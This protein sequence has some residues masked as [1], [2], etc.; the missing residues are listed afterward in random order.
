MDNMGVTRILSGGGGGGLKCAYTFTSDPCKKM[1]D[2]SPWS[3]QERRIALKNSFSVE[4][5]YFVYF[6]LSRSS[7]YF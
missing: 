4:Y 1:F 7:Y 5:S 2:R 6:L 3:V